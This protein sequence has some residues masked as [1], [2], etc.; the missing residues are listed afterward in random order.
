M[1]LK[2]EYKRQ[3]VLTSD[4]MAT[5]LGTNPKNIQMNYANNRDFFVEGK[6]YYKVAG[7]DLKT[8]RTLIE[9]AAT[10]SKNQPNEIGSVVRLIEEADVADMWV[11]EPTIGLRA[12]SLMLWTRRG[13]CSHAK[14]L[15]TRQAWKLYDRMEDVYFA[16]LEGKQP[17]LDAAPKASGKLHSK[18]KYW[19]GERVWTVQ[20]VLEMYPALTKDHI[21]YAAEHVLTSDDTFVLKGSALREYKC[22]NGL[23]KCKALRLLT[24]HGVTKVAAYYNVAVVPKASAPTDLQEK[25]ERIVTRAAEL[26]QETAMLA[27]ELQAS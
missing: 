6:H 22:A 19:R 16:V 8:L 14:L 5:V 15:T 23:L 17:Q 18:E 12:A 7:D 21:K 20:D 9:G 25:L 27:R 4:Q 13:L 2:L 24:E 11:P 1:M 10:G 3:L 26:L